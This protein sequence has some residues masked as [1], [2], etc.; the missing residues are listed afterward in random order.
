[1]YES[2]PSQRISGERV[3]W[4]LPRGLADGAGQTLRWIERPE[5]WHHIHCE[6]R[7]Y[8][9]A[10]GQYESGKPCMAEESPLTLY[11]CVQASVP[12]VSELGGSAV[13]ASESVGVAATGHPPLSLSL[14]GL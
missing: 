12:K 13:S 11:V 9:V 3:A 8:V 10:E 7:P 2:G 1:M 14:R 5:E 6:V 4:D